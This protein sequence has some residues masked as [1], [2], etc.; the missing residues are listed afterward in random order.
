MDFL[1][2]GRP[3]QIPPVEGLRHTQPLL[4]NDSSYVLAFSTS[5]VGALLFPV[6]GIEG[7][8]EVSAKGHSPT[9]GAGG[10]RYVELQ[11]TTNFSFLRGASHPDELVSGRKY[12]LRVNDYAEVEPILAT[13][14]Q[15]GA[16]IEDMQLHQADLEDVFIQIMEGEK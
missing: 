5:E 14:R 3:P 7:G 16:V 15:S 1:H 11:I 10:G 12:T 8:R 4:T 13:L 2:D 9:G 6:G